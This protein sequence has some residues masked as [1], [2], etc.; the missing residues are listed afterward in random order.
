[1]GSGSHGVEQAGVALGNLATRSLPVSSLSWQLVAHT[2]WEKQAVI[3]PPPMCT[4]KKLRCAVKLSRVADCRVAMQDPS[5][6]AP[7]TAALSPDPE[8]WQGQ[9]CQY[10]RAIETPPALEGSP[11][12]LGEALIR[13]GKVVW[14]GDSMARQGMSGM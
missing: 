4:N 11:G 9:L 3:L 10:P 13:P 14:Q 2:C 6:A 8:T 1:M 7:E 12:A 5:L